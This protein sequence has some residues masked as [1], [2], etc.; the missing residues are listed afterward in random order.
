M[1]WHAH[2]LALRRQSHDKLRTAC[3]ASLPRRPMASKRK[4]TLAEELMELT[5]IEPRAAP[6]VADVDAF[7]GDGP[8]L[9]D[10]DEDDGDED[11]QDTRRARRR[12]ERCCSGNRPSTVASR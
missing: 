2:I 10:V 9:V 5:H 11:R 1:T 6:D 8:V 7:G 4:R 12:C 3:R